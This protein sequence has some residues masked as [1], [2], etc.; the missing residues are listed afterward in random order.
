MT[1]QT[2]IAIFCSGS[3]SNA[4]KIIEHFQQKNDYIVQVLLANTPQALALKRAEKYGVSTYVFNRQ[5]F[6]ESDEVLN[7]L[8]RLEVDWIILAGFLWLI[9]EKLI[10]D[11]PSKIINIHPALLPKFGGKGMYGINVHRAVV[12]KKETTSGITIHFVNAHYDDGNIIF[13]A[14]CDL[15]QTDTA[16]DVARKVLALEHEHFPKVIEQTISSTTKK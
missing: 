16:E 4:E 7:E 13:Q 15:L 14:S 11:F 3:G 9:P 8:K 6:Y 5:A 2:K 1:K 12:E 10:N